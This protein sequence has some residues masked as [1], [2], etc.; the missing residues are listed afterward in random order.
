MPTKKYDLDDVTYSETGW[1]TVLNTI[2]SKLDAHIGSR[3]LRT[4]GESVSAY[5]VGYIHSDSKIYKAQGDGTKQPAIGMFLES[6]VLDD[7]VRIQRIGPVTNVAWNLTQG[8]LVYLS[9]DV[10]GGITQVTPTTNAQIVGIA[11]S[12]I[13]IFL[14][15]Q[16]AMNTFFSTV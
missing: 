14:N 12:D 4:L 16:L 9:E 1:Y 2:Y 5:E 10:T 3:T 11:L 7:Q 6:G 15:F 8:K 13:S